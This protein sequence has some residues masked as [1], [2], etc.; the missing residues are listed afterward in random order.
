MS[1][2]V[3]FGSNYC[4][5]AAKCSTVAKDRSIHPAH[6]W[7]DWHASYIDVRERGRAPKNLVKPPL[8]TWRRPSS[9]S[10]AAWIV[11]AVQPRRWWARTGLHSALTPNSR[12][13]PDHPHES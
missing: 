5:V 12:K 2:L 1:E 3:I 6:D 8:A 9:S 11:R 10:L 7:S 13:L 4:P